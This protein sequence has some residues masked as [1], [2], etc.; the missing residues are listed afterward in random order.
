MAFQHQLI[1]L[2]VA[3][4]WGTNFVLIKIGLEYFPPFLFVTLRFALVAFPLILLLP[5][6][7]VPW[8]YLVSYGVLIGFGQ[9]GL[10]FWA[11]QDDISPGLAALVIQTQ[12]FFTILLASYLYNEKLKILQAIALVVCASGLGLIIFHTAGTDSLDS[13]DKQTSSFGVLVVLIAAMSWA[14]GNVVYK[15]A[16]KDS[17]KINN[18]AFLAWSSIFAI[19]PL[20]LTSLYLEG[21]DLILGSI[22]TANLSAW[23]ILAW[24]TIGNTLI[25]YGLWNVLLSK[26]DTSKVTPWALMVPV[27]GLATSNLLLGEILPWWKLVAAMLILSGLVL[28][29]LAT[30]TQQNQRFPRQK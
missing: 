16:S 26:Y 10:L 27:F 2:L 24:Q 23:S 3:F 14:I 21:P 9:F 17:G 8:T 18:I 13:I 5:R 15:K 25:G 28:N 1:A 7:N 6:P 12:V 22:Q 29:V 30:K 19:P 4:I 11:M 20:L